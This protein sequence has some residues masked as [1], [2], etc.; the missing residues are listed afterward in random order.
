MKDLGPE[1]WVEFRY[2][3]KER[4]RKSTTDQMLN[5]GNKFIQAP[6]QKSSIKAVINFSLFKKGTF[7]LTSLLRKE[8]I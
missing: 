5:V 6:K 1:G 8:A 4:E 2:D 3:E 7:I